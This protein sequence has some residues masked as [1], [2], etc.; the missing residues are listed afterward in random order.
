MAI[1]AV[2]DTNVLVSALITKQTES[3]PRQLFRAMLDGRIIPLYNRELVAEYEA[4]LTR[5][6]FH[7]QPS[8]V[9]TVLQ[10][11]CN[12]GLEVRVEGRAKPSA[13]TFVDLDDL[14]FYQVVMA[15]QAVRAYLVTG[16]LKHYPAR[17]FIVT[18]AEM[19]KILQGEEPFRLGNDVMAS[20][21]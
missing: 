21:K 2:I 3:P 14:V 18:P 16:N 9:Q 1:Y 4:V 20:L 12:F 13:E 10:G 15:K 8:T 11:L 17:P 6:K 7:L 19:L 5:E